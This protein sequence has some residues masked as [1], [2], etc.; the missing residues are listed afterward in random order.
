MT[1]D[2][3]EMSGVERAD[4]NWSAESCVIGRFMRSGSTLLLS[5]AKIKSPAAPI[6]GP[7]WQELIGYGGPSDLAPELI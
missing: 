7:F 2:W 5:T 1:V 3:E 4:E 6:R